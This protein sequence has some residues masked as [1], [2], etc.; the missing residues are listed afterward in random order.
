MH[1]E[2]S[3]NGSEAV[4]CDASSYVHATGRLKESKMYLAMAP[5]RVP[6]TDGCCKICMGCCDCSRG[7]SCDG[8]KIEMRDGPC[9][10]SCDSSCHGS[11]VGICEGDTCEG[12][13]DGSGVGM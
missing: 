11:T 2:G 8:L 12:S 7:G 9:D 4:I 10:S 1:C 6:E 5:G 13:C 3:A